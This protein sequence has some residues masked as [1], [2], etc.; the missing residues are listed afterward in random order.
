MKVDKDR[1]ILL[2]KN[3][4]E[5]DASGRSDVWRKEAEQALIRWTSKR[6]RYVL[7]QCFKTYIFIELWVFLKTL[8]VMF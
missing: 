1:N 7:K 6:K 4:K 3:K 5:Y 2:T 8:I